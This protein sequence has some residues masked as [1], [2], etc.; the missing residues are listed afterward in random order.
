MTCPHSLPGVY[1]SEQL[2]ARGGALW[3]AAPPSTNGRRTAAPAAGTRPSHPT[4]PAPPPRSFVYVTVGFSLFFSLLL[5]LP[6]A[7][8]LR[9]L[10]LYLDS[11]AVSHSLFAGAWWLVLALTIQ[12]RGDQVWPSHPCTTV[13]DAPTASASPGTKVTPTLPSSINLWQAGEAGYPRSSQRT[14][15]ITLAWFELAFWVAVTA[16]A[17]VDRVSRL[18]PPVCLASQQ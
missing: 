1:A 11:L 18:T 3:H 10:S 15:V 2:C 8:A 5:A 6:T 14:A 12:I 16:L 7:L 9:R 4:A 17:A 13:A